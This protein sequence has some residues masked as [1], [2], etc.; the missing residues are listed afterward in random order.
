MKKKVAIIYGGEGAE[1]AISQKSAENL[2]SYID[3][4]R[5]TPLPVEIKKNGDWYIRTGLSDVPTFPIVK[6]GKGGFILDSEF[7]SVFCAVICLHGEYGEDGNVQGTLRTA[8]IPYIGQDVYASSLTSDK[9]YTKIIAE[10]LGI[11]TARWMIS[12]A[13]D[14][15]AVKAEAEEKIGYPMF[16]KP[17]RLGSSVGAHPV[18]SA[19]E[20]I[21]AYSEALSH[22]EKR[23]LIEELVNIKYEAECAFLETDKK[24]FIPDGKI[25]TD[26]KFYG[27]REKYLENAPKTETDPDGKIEIQKKMT[28]YSRLLVDSI[29]IRHISRI[30]FFV[31]EDN[32]VIF[33]EINTVPGMTDTSLYPKLTEN[34]GLSKGEFINRLIERITL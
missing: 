22:G 24:H 9:A 6:H 27:Y 31:T 25:F 18:Y 32:K 10:H 8:H 5:Y 29:G 12:S 15:K 30:D 7:I 16:I 4:K 23:I 21:N 19:E 34:T 33:N 2:I 13:L 20:F 26:G 3:K 14:A 17:A 1:N 11:P 28:E